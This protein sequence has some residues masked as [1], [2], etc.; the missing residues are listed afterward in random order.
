[1]AGTSRAVR[2]RSAW[3]Q[4]VVPLC[5]V[6]RERGV[7]VRF[8]RRVTE[9]VFDEATGRIEGAVMSGHLAAPALTGAPALDAIVGY[10]FAGRA[11]RTRRR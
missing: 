2:I 4:V 3:C 9:L 6:A 11:R 10:D 8:F 1:M 7:D 5:R